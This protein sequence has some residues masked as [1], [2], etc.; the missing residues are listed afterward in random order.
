[1]YFGGLDCCTNGGGKLGFFN[2]KELLEILAKKKKISLS[3]EL[4]GGDNN[5]CFLTLARLVAIFSSD[6]CPASLH[7]CEIMAVVCPS[8]LL[9]LGNVQE[10]FFL[11]YIG[12]RSLWSDIW[13]LL[14]MA[15]TSCWHISVLTQD[16][17]VALNHIPVNLWCDQPELFL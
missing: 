7:W 16:V 6:P 2:K 17:F 12:T 9:K 15:K 10:S 11:L 4:P 1:M 5:D 13:S 8:G 14:T 3:S